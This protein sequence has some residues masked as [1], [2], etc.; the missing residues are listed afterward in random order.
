MT[1]HLIACLAPVSSLSV[2]S[3]LRAR[4][5]TVTALPVTHVVR[6]TRLAFDNNLHASTSPAE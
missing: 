6:T 2:A 5:L 3:S 4:Y 1:L